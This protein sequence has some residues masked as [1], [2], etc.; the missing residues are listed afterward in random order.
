MATEIF[1]TRESCELCG[2]REKTILIDKSF[3][4]PLIWSFIENFYNGRIKK[5]DL[6]NGRFKVAKCARCGF[7]W[8]MEALND[9]LIS[10]MYNDWIDLSKSVTK[11]KN[12][13]ISVYA[14]YA[15]EAEKAAALIGKNPSEVKVLDF[16]M[17]WGYWCLMMKVFG[18]DVMGFELARE[19]VELAKSNG[20]NVLAD[21]AEIGRHKFDYINMR[22]A[23]EHIKNP[24]QVLRNL[25]NSLNEGGIVMISVP[26]GNKLEKKVA[27]FGW[28]PTKDEIFPLEHINCF[29]HKTLTLFGEMAGLKLIS[30]P[31]LL[32]SRPNLKSYLKGILSK[33]YRQYWGTTLYFRK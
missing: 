7:M 23:I 14:G 15:R 2:S 5:E 29:T 6:G 16:G 32:G 24:L 10:K 3:I 22:D 28:R 30:Q 18:F 19:R 8:Q 9:E 4:E 33:Y 12:A 27:G 31:F 13:D 21:F 20:I 11:R 1:E 25:V 26:N 17:G